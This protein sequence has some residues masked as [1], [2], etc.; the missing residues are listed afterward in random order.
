[1]R[2][3]LLLFVLALVALGGAF[4]AGLYVAW[5][6]RPVQPVGLS[7]SALRVAEKEEYIRM[8]ADTYAVDGDLRMARERLSR[9]NAGNSRQWVADLAQEAANNDRDAQARRLARLAFALDV[10][11]PVVRELA[12]LATGTPNPTATPLVT[13]TPI[14]SPTVTPL[15]PESQGGRFDWIVAERRRLS[16]EEEPGDGLLLAVRV[17][18]ADGD[19]VA[20]VPLRVEWGDQAERFFTG[21][22][23]DDPGYADFDMT[24]DRYVVAVDEGQSELALDLTTDEL[25]AQCTDV[26][27]DE[28]VYHGWFVRFR[29]TSP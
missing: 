20:G 1:M 18:D 4:A 19:P 17:E 9:L 27:G 6:V 8:V 28:P 24:A 5:I 22:Q 3:Q 26:A 29:R 10:D 12:A 15:P 7:P 23:S 2:R 14:P 21:L 11:G 16:C 13:P 25:D